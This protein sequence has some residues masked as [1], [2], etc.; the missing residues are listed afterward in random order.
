MNEALLIV[1]PKFADTSKVN[2][3]RPFSLIHIVGK[4]LSKV[5]ANR[6]VPKLNGFVHI[7][8]SV[9]INGRFT[10]DN[11]K[12][13]QS[14]AKQLHARKCASLL[15]KVDITKAFDSVAWPFLLE[16]MEHI[17]FSRI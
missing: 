1:L 17:G 3:Y 12:M 8:E 9:F 7:S 15:L 14:S 11:F 16:I 4:L 13:V 10:Q 2:H 6:L 5:L